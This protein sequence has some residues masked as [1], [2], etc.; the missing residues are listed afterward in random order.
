M[1]LSFRIISGFVLW[2]KHWFKKHVKPVV[3]SRFFYQ[4][5]SDFLPLSLLPPLSP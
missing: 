1:D 2:L 3:G 4:T 5:V